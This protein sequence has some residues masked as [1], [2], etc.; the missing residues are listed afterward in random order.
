V[1]ALLDTHI[2]LWWAEDSKRLSAAQRR[3]LKRANDEAA[4][5]LC[6]VC[7]GLHNRRSP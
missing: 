5:G 1:I 4:L 7:N 6:N 2:P 3:V